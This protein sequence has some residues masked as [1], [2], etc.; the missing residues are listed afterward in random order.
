MVQY[1]PHLA[2]SYSQ[3]KRIAPQFVPHNNAECR[4]G[5]RPIITVSKYSICRETPG[6]VVA[7]CSLVRRVTIT[8]DSPR[9]DVGGPRAFLQPCT[10]GAGRL[11][12]KPWSVR[13]HGKHIFSNVTSNFRLFPSVLPFILLYSILH[14][15][16]EIY[17]QVSVCDYS[18]R[19]RFVYHV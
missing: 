18:P 14:F 6:I 17:S 16:R 8:L 13:E 4:E 1:R 5:N 2:L 9:C 7:L 10:Y 12:S 15:Y 11:I 19:S 3:R